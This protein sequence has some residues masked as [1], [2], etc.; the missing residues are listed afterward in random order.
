M[1]PSPISSVVLS[2]AE[3]RS[4]T[5]ESVRLEVVRRVLKYVS[6]LPWGSPAAE[7]GRR[8]ASLRRI[9]DALAVGAEI[10]QA[11]EQ[12]RPMVAGGG[13]LWTPVLITEDGRMKFEVKDQG[14]VCSHALAWLASRQAPIRRL[15]APG[16]EIDLTE[17]V[18]SELRRPEASSLEIL[19]DCRFVLTIE[20]RLLPQE[21]ISALQTG[22]SKL[23]ITAHS[24]YFLPKLVVRGEEASPSEGCS[25]TAP[26]GSS[27]A[28][29]GLGR[30]RS[31]LGLHVYDHEIWR[32]SPE[33]MASVQGIPQMG[34]DNKDGT[35][36][37]V[38]RDTVRVKFIRELS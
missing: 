17:R 32:V 37:G 6:P 10:P 7:A 35:R 25:D 9:S 36:S 1:R 38:D 33:W 22:K 31:R 27:D 8:V 15:G 12:R 4:I 13:V 21:V 11:V 26:A 29:S 14:M 2:A 34:E 18:C 23:M 20:P 30:E 5:E 3:F 28:S 16:L 19:Y 24:R